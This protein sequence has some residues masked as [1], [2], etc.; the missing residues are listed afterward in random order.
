METQT[1]M[2]HTKIA[3]RKLIEKLVRRRIGASGLIEIGDSFEG[4]KNQPD[5]YEAEENATWGAEQ[6][7]EPSFFCHL[8]FWLEKWN[9]SLVYFKS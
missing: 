3:P 2:C 8:H 9:S 6:D 5:Q 1:W 4:M 7:V